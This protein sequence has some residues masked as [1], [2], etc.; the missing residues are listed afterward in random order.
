MLASDALQEMNYCSSKFEH[1]YERLGYVVH[2]W[3][4]CLLSLLSCR[5]N[6][7]SINQVSRYFD[8]LSFFPFDNLLL[9]VLGTK[10]VSFTHQ[11][12]C[13]VHQSTEQVSP[14]GVNVCLNSFPHR[15]TTNLAALA[16]VLLMHVDDAAE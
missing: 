13:R 15:G 16:R 3:P 8:T 2:V 5:A 6:H 9:L 11:R 10:S 12:P 14:I 1:G 4:C 7:Q